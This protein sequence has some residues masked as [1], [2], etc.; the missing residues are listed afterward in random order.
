MNDLEIIKQIEEILDVKLEKKIEIGWVSKAYS[1]NQSGQV[2]GVGLNDCKIDNKKL[3]QL[4]TSLKEFKSLIKL[5]LT[6]NKIND[7]FSLKELKNLINLDLTKNQISD[8]SSLKELKS[9]TKLILLFNQINDISWLKGLKG[10]TYLY[11]SENQINDISSL[12]ELK[13][14][15]N[16]DLSENQINDISSLNGLKSLTYLNLSGNK[17]T[18]ISWLK[19]LKSLTQLNLSD[20]LIDDISWLKDLKS[21]TYL[22]LPVNQINDITSLKEL[23]SLKELNLRNNPIE[24]LPEWITEFKMNIRWTNTYQLTG[25]ITFFNNP[26]KSPPVEIVKQGKEAIKRHFEK[27]KKEGLDY[28]YEAKLTLVGE[29][30]SGKTSLQL[31]LMNPKSLLPK[32]DE[33]TRGI[34]IEDWNF[35]NETSKKHIAHIWDFGGQDVYYPVH[36]FFLT[37]NSVFVLLASTRITQHNFDYWIPTIFQFGGKSPIILGQTCHKGNKVSWNDIGSFLSNTDFNIVRINQI[38]YHQLNL[39]NNNEGLEAIKETIIEQILKLPHYGKGVPKSWIPVREKL[40]ELAVNSDCITYEKFVEICREL[41]PEQFEKPVDIEDCARFFHSIGVILWYYNTEELRNT[42]VLKPEWALNAVYKLI[43]D[44]EVQT[45]Q[46]IITAND[47]KRL[48]SDG[49]FTDKHQIL[50][51]MLEEFRIAFHKKH[52]DEYIIAAR[53][54]S[55]PDEKKWKNNEADLRLEY[56]YEFMPRG[57]VN[58]LS[59]E[60]SRYISNDNEVWNN[61]VNF[62]FESKTAQSQVEEDFYN[63]KISI[64]AKGTDARALNMLIMDSLKNITE[65][66]KGVFPQIVVPCNCEKCVNNKNPQTYSYDMLIQKISNNEKA[67][68]MCNASDKIFLVEELL[69][70]LGL[71]NPAKEKREMEHNKPRR[72]FI[73]SSSELKDDRKDFELAIHRKNDIWIKKG[74]YLQPVMWENFIDTMSQ[75]RLQDEYNIAAKE[76]DIFVML[77]FSKVGIFTAEEFESAFGKFKETG[78]PLIYTYFKNDEIKSGNLKEDDSISFFAF[79]KKLR[80]LGHYQTEYTNTE[81]LILHFFNQLEKLLDA[82]KL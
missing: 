52:N 60:L 9:L 79:K 53:L 31:R 69:F 41:R 65:G 10:L 50:K 55:M 61:A 21:L 49:C 57:L 44:A 17:I 56:N 12:K 29:G 20:N 7:I 48:W 82:G 42:L 51:K 80:D 16:L 5:S 32:E 67:K 34:N 14:L 1:L 59:A 58:Q 38:P 63:R 18:D 43:D 54:L 40:A 30:A 8:I 3:K 22:N 35:K 15:T 75:T 45:H 27:I 13:N 70:N 36:R 25:L 11:L 23:K 73:A 81:S 78:K 26:L 39:L 76:S 46:G 47:F 74:I 33:R 6:D 4:I 72:I 2:T 71:H 68:V 19:D 24:Q 66:Y 77:F 37:E 62:K 28:I 64:K